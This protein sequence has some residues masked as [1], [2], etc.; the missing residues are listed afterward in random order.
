MMYGILLVRVCRKKV[1]LEWV[2]HMVLEDLNGSSRAKD[3]SV[4]AV[5]SRQYFPDELR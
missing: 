1:A 3:Y 5:R 2:R 4:Y